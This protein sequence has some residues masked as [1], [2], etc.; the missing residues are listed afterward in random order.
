MDAAAGRSVLD[1]RSSRRMPDED[2]EGED[3]MDDAKMQADYRAIQ[4]LDQYDPTMLAADGDAAVDHDARRAAEIEMARRDA[5]RGLRPQGLDDDDY[6]DEDQDETYQDRQRRLKRMRKAAA[7][8]EPEDVRHLPAAGEYA[9]FELGTYSV[10]LREWIAQE[11]TRAE[12]RRRF[13][14][15]LDNYTDAKGVN[16]HQESIETMCAENNQTLAVSYLAMTQ[17]VPLLAVWAADAPREMLALMDGVAKEKVLAMYP[18]YES[19]HDEIYVR[20]GDF[21]ILDSLRDLRHEHLNVLVRVSGVVT[22]RTGVFPQLKVARYTCTKCGNVTEPVVV[23][24]DGEARLGACTECQARGP[25]A[26]NSEQTVYRNYQKIS[27]QEAP[28]SVPAG[29]VPRYKEV[30][31]LG[32][33]IDAARPG[34]EVEVTGIFSNSYD[35]SLNSRQG[36]PVFATVLEANSVRKRGDALASKGLTDEDK[37]QIEELA[38]DPAI[39]QRIVRSI[40]PSIFGNE[41]AKLA[42]AL[43]MFGGRQKDVSGK[44]RIRGDINVLLLGDP[45][46]AKSQVLKYVEKTASRAVYSTGKGASA[47]GL[48]AAVHRDP[49]TGEWTLEGGALVLADRGVCLIDEFDK[50]NDADRTSIHEAMEQQSIS[51]SKAGIVTSLQA[52]CSVIAAANPIGGRYDPSKTFAENVQLTDPILQRFDILCVLQDTVDP[53]RDEELARFVVASHVRSHPDAERDDA[54]A[55]VTD[56]AT[57]PAAAAAA[58]A[59]GAV[60]TDGTSERGGHRSAV[61]SDVPSPARAAAAAAGASS[62]GHDH[63]SSAGD[64]P[65][66]SSSSSSSS[67]AAAAA[68]AAAGGR[69]QTAL[70]AARRLSDPSLI[71]QELLQKYIVHARAT[72]RPSL[73][74][75]N[76]ARIAKLYAELRRESEVSDGIPIAV[77][78]IE[79][80]I[81]MSESHARMH[82]RPAVTDAD[83]NMAIRTMLESFI[84]AQKF[85]VM[86]QLRRQFSKYLDYHRDFRQLLLHELNGLVKARS[87]LANLLRKHDE[88]AALGEAADRDIRVPIK[89]LRAVAA[90]YDV[91]SLDDFLGSGEFRS[92]GFRVEGS[93]VVKTI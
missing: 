21:P 70:D 67:A 17:A 74:D 2:S 89:E 3:L 45:G 87:S 81:R 72:C 38:R 25:F 42:V 43:A 61:T 83:V 79:S 13:R 52:R 16:V 33:L 23:G 90:R 68:G 63:R 36:F 8:D 69:G 53:V 12:V 14:W 60:A 86:R 31:L 28:G 1:D 82:F 54:A 35:A 75:I 76:Q 26:L 47:V 56:G 40:A 91:T 6:F 88:A 19:I 55:G 5:A 51:I 27:L 7:G 41:H 62:A 49:M 30:I 85:S 10:P 15:F 48:T 65:S 11:Q 78:H 50:M 59:G 37:R 46:T 9:P 18:D 84:Q 39:G 57:A 34:E 58:A 32:D 73:T 4:E 44:H 29:R 66:S 20:I 77:R 80:I 22:R 71:P 93:N 64:G 92:H 24:R